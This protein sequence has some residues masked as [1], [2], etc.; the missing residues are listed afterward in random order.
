M[1]I[2]IVLAG[3]LWGYS[4]CFA[5]KGNVINF[6]NGDQCAITAA[7]GSVSYHVCPP[8]GETVNGLMCGPTGSSCTYNGQ[9][10]TVQ[11]KKHKK[12]SGSNS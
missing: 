3:M 8:T 9:Q 2:G 1:K 5:D 12:V 4:T 10:G 6:F 11:K 7:D